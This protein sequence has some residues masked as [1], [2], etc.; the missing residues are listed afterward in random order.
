MY[1]HTDSLPD[2]FSGPIEKKFKHKPLNE[3]RLAN[4]NESL[5]N[6]FEILKGAFENRKADLKHVDVVRVL[7]VRK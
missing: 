6:Q 4:R 5:P 2:Q 7:R 3:I 1:H